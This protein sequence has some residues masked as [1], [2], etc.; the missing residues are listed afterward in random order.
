MILLI[1]IYLLVFR[2]VQG[3][4]EP[5]HLALHHEDTRRLPSKMEPLRTR[6][7]KLAPTMLGEDVQVEL[8]A[9]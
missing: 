5:H 9:R 4:A 8:P 7:Y 6:G 3:A 2:R 1:M